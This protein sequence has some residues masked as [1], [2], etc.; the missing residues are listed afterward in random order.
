VTTK[1]SARR[2]RRE[3]T[4]R[5][6]MQAENEQGWDAVMATFAPGRARY[7]L[8]ASGEVH[9]GTDEV[10]AYWLAGRT[11]VPDQTNELIELHHAD[12]AVMIE[13]RLTGTPIADLNPQGRSFDA[14]LAA[15]FLFEPDGDLITG[16]RV[17]WDRATI[18]DQLG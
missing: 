14:R 16:E 13:F 17:Y 18:L 8:M 6:H 4:V 15:L 11:M 12:D 3:D 10:M 2:E 9:D 1:A 7:E 5:T